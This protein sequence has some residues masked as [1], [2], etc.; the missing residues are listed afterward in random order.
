M[1]ILGGI[2]K[3]LYCTIHVFS[4]SLQQYCLYL[5]RTGMPTLLDLMMLH[6]QLGQVILL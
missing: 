4:G 2:Y 6:L 3:E 1:G 5:W